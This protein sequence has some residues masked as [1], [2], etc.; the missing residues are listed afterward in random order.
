[1]SDHIW[2]G[3]GSVA[4]IAL[5]IR[6]P[7]SLQPAASWW[8]P[9]GGTQHDRGTHAAAV[10]CRRAA[11]TDLGDGGLLMQ[12]A[13]ESFDRRPAP[14]QLYG[15]IR[16]RCGVYAPREQLVDVDTLCRFVLGEQHESV[17]PQDRSSSTCARSR[18][19]CG[20]VAGDLQRSTL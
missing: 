20:L 8:N 3:S 11:G 9:L 5:F 18:C 6:Q 12:A 2:A 1:M 15:W 14:D 16:A 4:I 10:W 13:P 19:T 7:A 17:S